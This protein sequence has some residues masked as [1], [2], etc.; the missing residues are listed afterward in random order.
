MLNNLMFFEVLFL[1]NVEIRSQTN[2]K[3]YD[4]SN[5]LKRTYLV[6]NFLLYGISEFEG[7]DFPISRVTSREGM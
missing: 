7:S 3:K 5:L 2:I 6:W 1:L 4:F